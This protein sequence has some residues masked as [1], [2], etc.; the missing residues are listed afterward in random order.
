MLE[1]ERA[2]LSPSL[3]DLLMTR[4]ERLP[5]AAQKAADQCYPDTAT[6]LYDGLEA[7]VKLFREYGVPQ[8]VT[9][10]RDVRF[11]GSSAARD[12]PS[13]LMRLLLCLGVEVIVC[14]PQRP[15]EKPFVERYR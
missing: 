14:P 12:F 15:Q 13:A 7:V 5:D 10:D 11:V 4:V 6:K 9:L 2:T 8:S 1:S 3:R